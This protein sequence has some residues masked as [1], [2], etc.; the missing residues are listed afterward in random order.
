MS[1]SDKEYRS[2]TKGRS[3]VAKE[4][5]GIEESEDELSTSS[6]SS[7]S[8]SKGTKDFLVSSGEEVE[9]CEETRKI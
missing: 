5:K 6:P 8:D 7:I 1:S 3:L 2:P 4:V 9:I